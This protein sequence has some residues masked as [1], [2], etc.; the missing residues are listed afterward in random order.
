MRKTWRQ[1]PTTC[2]L[3]S[4][5][6]EPLPAMLG[7]L[8]VI[9]VWLV[10]AL[11]ACP[12]SYYPQRLED[13]RAVY[14]AGPSGGDDTAALQQA[15]DRVRE[16]GGQGIVLLGSGRY[17]IN[18][19]LYVWPG[20]RVIGYGASR[21]VIVLSANTPAFQEPTREKVMVFFA[22]GRPGSGRSRSRDSEG[23]RSPVP[24]ANPGTFY[25]ALSNTDIE[26]EDGN[27]G[28]VAVRSRYAQHC[29]LAHMDLRLGSALAGIHGAG[30]VIERTSTSSA[31]ATGF[32]AS[33]H[34]AGSSR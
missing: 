3:S 20:I 25:S 5:C 21:P 9:L 2:E 26:I 8:A 31:A 22:G 14:V 19:T 4:V 23:V 30:N 28:A 29:F 12:A 1:R 13:P 34:R 16:T 27:P 15:I 6:S 17:R 33:P 18:D 7:R 24:D 11:P 10:A 32:H